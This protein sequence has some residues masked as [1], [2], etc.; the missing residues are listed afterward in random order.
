VTQSEQINELVAALARAQLEYVPVHKDSENPYFNSQYADLA[1]VIKAT[2]PALAKYGLVVTQWPINDVQVQEAGV[3]SE[4]AHSSGQWKRMEL[5]LPAVGQAKAGGTKYDAQTVGTAI[6][7]ARR[8][9]YQ[10]IVGVAAEL[11]DDANSIGEASGAGEAS[12]RAEADRQIAAHNAR[13]SKNAIGGDSRHA[14]PE[15]AQSA[16]MPEKV[17]L[18]AQEGGLVALSGPGLNIV[19]SEM[20]N[21]DRAFF[22]IVNKDRQFVFEEK[23]VFNFQDLCKRVGVEWVWTEPTNTTLPRAV[24]PP[25]PKFP[26]EPEPEKSTDPILIEAREVVKEGKKPFMSLDWSGQKHSCF[27]RGV[28]PILKAAV[29]KPVMLETKANGKYS[30]LV[31]ILRIDGIS[32]E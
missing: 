12:A 25:A 19:R 11:D 13:K 15:V 22:Q 14:K 20:T 6:T 26:N 32:F 28:W 23:L 21:D 30:N 7:Y 16:K 17:F 3:I 27:D 2:Q 5:M 29:G 18:T 31:K 24:I 8:Y 1:T 10:A 9:S 4:L